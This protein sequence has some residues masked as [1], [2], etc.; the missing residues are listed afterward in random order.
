MQDSIHSASRDMP[1]GESACGGAGNRQTE[2]R[3]QVSA[4]NSRLVNMV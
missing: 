1:Q 2:G 3:Q 4:V